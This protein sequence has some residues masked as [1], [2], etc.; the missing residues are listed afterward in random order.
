MISLKIIILPSIVFSYRLLK[1]LKL[2]LR[3]G[4]RQVKS[5]DIKTELEEQKTT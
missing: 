5:F 3:K 1:M 4:L 2:L